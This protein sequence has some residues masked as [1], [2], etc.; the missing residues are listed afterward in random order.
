MT[1][2]FGSLG[3]A[4]VNLSLVWSLLFVGTGVAFLLEWKYA[5]R[6]LLKVRNHRATVPYWAATLVFSVAGAMASTLFFFIR[7]FRATRSFD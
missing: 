3:N 7:S 6:P 1:L 5:K 2:D 4:R